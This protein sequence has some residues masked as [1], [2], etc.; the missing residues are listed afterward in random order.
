MTQINEVEAG[1]NE[2]ADKEAINEVELNVNVPIH[3]AP[4]QL[5]LD[6]SSDTIEETI[7]SEIA[8][9]H[10]DTG[11]EK[12]IILDKNDGDNLPSTN[13]TDDIQITLGQEVQNSQDLDEN[14]SNGIDIK[15]TEVSECDGSSKTSLIKEGPITNGDVQSEVNIQNGDISKDNND[16]VDSANESLV[17]KSIISVEDMLAD[18]VDEVNEEAAGT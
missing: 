4:T 5:P 2:H 9:D 11:N 13:E 18:F 16:L 10:P 15:S 6:I 1:N 12:V 3:E 14:M 17:S 8:Y 7:S